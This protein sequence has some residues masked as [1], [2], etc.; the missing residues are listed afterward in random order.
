MNYSYS[1]I[2]TAHPNTLYTVWSITKHACTFQNL[3]LETATISTRSRTCHQS[4]EAMMASSAM[5]FTLRLQMSPEGFMRHLFAP[6]F[7]HTEPQWSCTGHRPRPHQPI[8]LIKASVKG[9]NDKQNSNSLVLFEYFQIISMAQ[10][11]ICFFSPGAQWVPEH[12]KSIP[13]QLSNQ[14]SISAKCKVSGPIPVIV[15]IRQ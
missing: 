11:P 3:F 8:K 1:A 14:R 4:D 15:H 5:M 12:L 13:D 10:V 7:T 9:N 6:T 2:F